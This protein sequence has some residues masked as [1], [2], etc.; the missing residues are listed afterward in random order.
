M[1]ELQRLKEAVLNSQDKNE[2]YLAEVELT[3]INSRLHK[4]YRLTENDIEQTELR[5]GMS[6]C[7]SLIGICKERQSEVGNWANKINYNFRMAARVMLKPATYKK[8]W[9]KAQLTRQDV[10][11]E[12]RELN[13]NKLE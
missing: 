13:A 5:G 2:L 10:K 9:E 11:D 1:Q 8:I 3:E 4:S 7:A 6:L 12:K